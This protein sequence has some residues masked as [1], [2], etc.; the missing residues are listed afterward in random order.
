MKTRY[1]LLLAIAAFLALVALYLSRALPLTHGS[2]TYCLDD[3]YIHLAVAK[4]LV[5]HHIW[6]ISPDQ[7]SGVSSSLLW[8]LLLTG[9]F[10]IFGV[11]AYVPF[12]LNIVLVL[13]LLALLDEIWLRIQLN[14]VQRLVLLT[15]TFFLMP[16]ASQPFIGMEVMLQCFLVALFYYVSSREGAED[17]MRKHSASMLFLCGF[18]LGSVRYETILIV[19]LVALGMLLRGDRR[20][21]LTLAVAGA[22]PATIYGFIALS[23]GGTFVP[24]TLF[25]KARGATIVGQ[26]LL[27]HGPATAAILAASILLAYLVFRKFQRRLFLSPP[28]MESIVILTTVITALAQGVLS[29]APG[30]FERYRTYLYL[31]FVLSFGAILAR[32]STVSSFFRRFKRG[33]ELASSATFEVVIGLTAMVILIALTI[34]SLPKFFFYLEKTP[35]ACKNIYDEQVQ[36]ARF[37]DLY[38]QRQPVAVVDIGAPSFYAESPLIDLIGLGSDDIARITFHQRSSELSAMGGQSSRQYSDTLNA[39]VRARHAR[40]AILYPIRGYSPDTSWIRM[41]A[42]VID[43]NY[44]C[45]NDTVGL[46]AMRLEDTAW[47]GRSLRDFRGKTTSHIIIP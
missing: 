35:I 17:P 46:Y 30:Q 38:C 43:S 4:N 33:R 47:L 41:G 12:I 40:L 6:G 3:A 39:I 44:V 10:A 28:S 36:E 21:G 18:L 1:P 14:S 45:A 16:L 34:A 15:G 7:W 42:L 20:R 19:E 22:L 29:N 11:N 2:I 23:F 9:L 32:P 8:T 31:S 25:L 26:E 37:I 24:N 13:A 5:H 27:S